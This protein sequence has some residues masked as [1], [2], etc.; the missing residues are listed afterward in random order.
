MTSVAWTVDLTTFE[1]LLVF[2]AES[3]LYVWD[4]A[5]QKLRDS[6]LGHGGVKG[7]QKPSEHALTLIADNLFNRGITSRS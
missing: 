7:A 4:A 5:K 3:W 2:S 6:F 1:P